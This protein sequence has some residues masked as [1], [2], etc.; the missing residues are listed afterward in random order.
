MDSKAEE[1]RSLAEAPLKAST[2]KGTS[3]H[4]PNI[5]ETQ[6]A[7]DVPD[8]DEDDLDDLDDMLDAFSP[9]RG[10]PNTESLNDPKLANSVGSQSTGDIADDDIPAE[11]FA[12][13]LQAGMANLLG[14]L[15]TDVSISSQNLCRKVDILQ[16][17]MQAQFADIMKEFGGVER[18][19]GVA[20]VTPNKVN[21]EAAKTP[22]SAAASAPASATEESFQETIRKTMERMQASEG[23]ASAAAA[24]DSEDILAELMKQMGSGAL[25]GEGSEE[26]F[27][28]M[29]L[30]MME[31][32][33][34]KEILYEPMKELNDKFP[35]WMES[36]IATTSKE[37]LKRYEEQQRVV[38]EI[39]ARFEEKTY[40]DE[41]A[42]DRKY[43][44]DRMQKVSTK[45]LDA[46]QILTKIRC[47]QRALHHQTSLEIWQ[48]LRK[49]WQ[50]QKMVVHNN[51]V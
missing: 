15:G 1:T 3:E 45:N 23:K 11:D 2:S 20:P 30:G 24:D 13:Q 25:G 28:K 46:S 16:P 42:A 44:V 12:K 9:A 6:P 21:S 40:S 34:N 18:L 27:S 19:E 38:K 8:P 33:T 29:L 26:D 43:I 22:A 7:D 31:Q 39:V 37:D 10:D 4:G 50:G 14:E 5:N 51:E 48:Q 35:A 41:N 17:D 36:N 32:L 47:K 49:P